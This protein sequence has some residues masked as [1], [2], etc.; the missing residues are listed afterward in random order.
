VVDYLPS[1]G[2]KIVDIFKKGRKN[3]KIN[4]L[5]PNPVSIDRKLTFFLAIS[6][7]I[8]L[9]LLFYYFYLAAQISSFRAE[10]LEPLLEP[11]Q[12]QQLK[13][14]LEE[15]SFWLDFSVTEKNLS[16]ICLHRLLQAADKIIGEDSRLHE[17]SYQPG[18]LKLRGQAG[19]IESYN[20]II[21]RLAVWR[22]QGFEIILERT[23][24]F[25]SPEFKLILLEVGKVGND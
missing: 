13:R 1:A 8:L 4:L 10:K 18:E 24:Y 22:S 20:N 21:H 16:A 14:E 15:I 23:G 12:E 5:W 6:A 11:E 17:I 7:L 25:A 9:L 3:S 19:D 2:K